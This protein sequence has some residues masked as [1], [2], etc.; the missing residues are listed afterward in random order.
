MKEHTVGVFGSV[1][2]VLAYYC[3]AGSYML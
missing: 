2:V 1:F 3:S